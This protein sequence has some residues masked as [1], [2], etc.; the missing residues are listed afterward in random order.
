MS[1]QYIDIILGA[2][3]K[4]NLSRVWSHTDHLSTV[5]RGQEEAVFD[6]LSACFI[7]A[8]QPGVHMSLE[9]TISKGCPGDSDSDYTLSFD[10]ER[11]NQESISKIDFAVIGK[12]SVYPLGSGNYMKVIERIVNQGIDLGVVSGSGHYATHLSGPVHQVFSYLQ[13]IFS[14][15]DEEVSHFVIQITLLC[16][17]PGGEIHE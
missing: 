1:D 17:V 10:H 3:E 2:L 15:L 5:Y 8:Y 14:M 7:Q 6:A 13:T 11:V 9:A 4:T 12:F 16:N